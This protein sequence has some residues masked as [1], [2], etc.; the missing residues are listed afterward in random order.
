MVPNAGVER[1]RLTG[2]ELV[3]HQCA[4]HQCALRLQRHLLAVVLHREVILAGPVGGHGV[5]KAVVGF[6][7]RHRHVH[8]NPEEFEQR[9]FPRRGK[10]LEYGQEGLEW[11]VAVVVLRPVIDLGSRIWAGHRTI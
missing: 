9:D 10:V 11:V 6:Q 3:V 7:H 1:F 8:R 4:R 2:E 5:H